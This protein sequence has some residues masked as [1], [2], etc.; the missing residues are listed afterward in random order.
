MTMALSLKDLLDFIE[1]ETYTFKVK[2]ADRNAAGAQEVES[3]FVW[4]PRFVTAGFPD[5]MTA[6]GF[7]NGVELGGIGIAK[8][9]MSHPLATMSSKGGGNAAGWSFN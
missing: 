7:R 4:I 6:K 2:H 5:S 8:Y 9:P 3:E 1:A